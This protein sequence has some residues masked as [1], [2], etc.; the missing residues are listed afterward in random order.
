MT[1]FIMEPDNRIVRFLRYLL[2]DYNVDGRTGQW[3]FPSF[4]REFK[5]SVENYPLVTV[6]L[7]NESGDPMGIGDP[8]TYDNVTVQIDIFVKDKHALNIRENGEVIVVDKTT[9]PAN[10]TTTFGVR[11]ENFL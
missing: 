8:D 4:P 7:L 5:S 3:I 1:D 2:P 9:Y 6:T 10:R 11:G